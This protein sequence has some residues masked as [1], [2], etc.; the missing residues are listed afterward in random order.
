MDVI[1]YPCPNLRQIMLV[2]RAGEYHYGD[3]IMGAIASQIASL[4]IVYSTVYSDA[5]Q[6]KHQSSTSLAFVQGIHR[7]PVNSSHKWPV[8]RKMFPFDDV[9]MIAWSQRIHTLL[10][11]A[12]IDTGYFRVYFV[13]VPSQWETTLHYNVGSH[14]QSAYIKW[15]LVI[16][17]ISSRI[18]SVASG[19]SYHCP[20]AS[21]TALTD[22]V[23]VSHETKG[24]DDDV[25][26]RKHSPLPLTKASDEELWCFLRCAPEQTAE[27]T[28]QMLAI[29]DAMALIMTSLWCHYLGHEVD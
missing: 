14:W 18:T 9:I 19:Q 25:I 28:V 4:T 26:K 13:N 12:L 16:L 27:Q 3:V 23:N 7:G 29:W 10:C 2:K 5:D 21:E 20:N 17:P 11:F 15:S 8:T 6:R 24:T 22:M 1:T